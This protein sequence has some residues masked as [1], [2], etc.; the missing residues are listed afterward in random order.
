MSKQLDRRGF[1]AGGAA[2]AVGYGFRHGDIASVGAE[3]YHGFPQQNAALV[4]EVVGVSHGNFERVR[5]L[6][7]A[8]PALAKAETDW[9]FGDWES[10]LGAASHT[11]NRD[12]AEYLIEK[13]ARPTLFS[14]TMLG[15]LDVVRAFVEAS[16]GVQRIPG[17]HGITLLAHARFGG[18]PAR[19]VLEYLELVG[20][21]DIGPSSLPMTETARREY[22]GSYSYGSN[23]SDRLEVL[24][25]GERLAIQ[26]ADLPA[27]GLVYL[28]DREFHP[29][30]AE[31][32][33]IRFSFEGDRA[34]IV[35]VHDP[36]VIVTA[37]RV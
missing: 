16:P 3:P 35:T 24:E 26:G 31:A 17:P 18:D 29:V 21:A 22:V 11:G 28:G 10:A 15:Q 6:V 20:D 33:R 9:S 7:G 12:I 1:L 8:S 23:S 30:G 4:R 2:V 34:A 36:D 13:G 32:V 14:A 25:R 27:R 19:E 5:E 37:R